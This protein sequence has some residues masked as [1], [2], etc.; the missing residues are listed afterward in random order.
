MHYV[1]R[2]KTE[3]SDNDYRNQLGKE[4]DSIEAVVDESQAIRHGFV[5]DERCTRSVSEI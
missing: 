4:A 1:L 5:V 3:Y 2:R